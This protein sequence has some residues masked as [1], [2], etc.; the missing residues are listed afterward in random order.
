M[1]KIITGP[2][3]YTVCTTFMNTTKRI[4]MRF[5]ML[6]LEDLKMENT[7]GQGVLLK[8]IHIGNL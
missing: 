2:W 7:K 5:S 3:I 8:E 4:I 6:G 1:N